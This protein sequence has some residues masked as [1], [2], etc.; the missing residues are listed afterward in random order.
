MSA[1]EGPAMQAAYDALLERF[2]LPLL[3]GGQVEIGRPIAPGCAPFFAATT[4]SSEEVRQRIFSAL[5]DAAD[6]IHDVET[7]PFPG[8]ALPWLAAAAHDLCALTDPALDR[9]FVRGVRPTIAAWTDRWLELVP[10]PVSRGDALARHALIAPLSQLRRT[11]TVVKNW[12]YTYRFHGRKPPA[13][14]VALPTIR[15]V[16]TVENTVGFDGLLAAEPAL[17]L[18]E[19]HARLVSRSP[20]TE[21]LVLPASFRFS[22]ATLTVLADPGLRSGIAKRLAGVDA[23][24]VLVR[25]LRAPELAAAPGLLRV[26]L[27][28]VTE[29]HLVRVLDGAPPPAARSEDALVFDALLVAAF[30]DPASIDGFRALDDGDRAL[31]QARA[32]DIRRALPAGATAEALRLFRAASE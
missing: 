30:D 7:V 12:A 9:L 11:D 16:R 26:A 21:L 17:A 20:V 14:V 28:F 23:G 24:P 13:N 3:E 1:V 27:D 31:V 25:A 18:A 2:V 4:P 29:L 8:G 19:R 22:I 10:P 6:E 5:V 32:E 15:F